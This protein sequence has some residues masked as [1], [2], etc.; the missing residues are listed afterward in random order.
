MRIVRTWRIVRGNLTAFT[1]A[2]AFAIVMFMGAVVGI[3]ALMQRFGNVQPLAGNAGKTTTLPTSTLPST[4]YYD[5]PCDMEP[6]DH[7]LQAC[8]AEVRRACM[9][10][11]PK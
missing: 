2:L 7:N 3:A 9:G 10:I 6:T 8:L 1:V 5:S 4:V 11:S